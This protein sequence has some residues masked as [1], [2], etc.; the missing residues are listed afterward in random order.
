MARLSRLLIKWPR[1]A[2][3]RPR[4]PTPKGG[5]F[6]CTSDPTARPCRGRRDE[7]LRPRSKGHPGFYRLPSGRDHVPLPRPP[8]AAPLGVRADDQGGASARRSE[9]K[10]AVERGDYQEIEGTLRRLRPHLA[11]HLR[12]PHR[13][14][15]QR[16]DPRRLPPPPRAGG[17]PVLWED[18]PGRDRA[19][20]R[21]GLRPQAAKQ[22]AEGLAPNTVRLAVAPV[23]A[24][25]ATAFEEGLIRSNPAAGCAS[26]SA[27]T[28]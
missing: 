26:R 17:D 15:D 6:R 20:G 13:A 8:R 5:T 4:G 7:W 1:R 16:D 19:A 23:R 10:L 21:E 28:T 22:N 27:V 9:L 25:L 12:R 18:A 11:R 24:L 2:R 14:R 3:Q